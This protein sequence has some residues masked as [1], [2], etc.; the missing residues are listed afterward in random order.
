ME[1]LG[2]LAVFGIGALVG[3]LGTCA[4]LSIFPPDPEEDYIDGWLDGQESARRA[5][6]R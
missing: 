3:A 4:V 5:R 2:L 1:T 6:D